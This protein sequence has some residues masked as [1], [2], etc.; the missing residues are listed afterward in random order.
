MQIITLGITHGEDESGNGFVITLSDPNQHSPAKNK[1]SRK[2]ERQLAKAVQVGLAT[3]LKEA[4]D[5]LKKK[6][7]DNLKASY[8]EDDEDEP[9]PPTAGNSPK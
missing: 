5:A 9:Q 4:L 2:L 7:G 3:W 6:M 8:C 1:D